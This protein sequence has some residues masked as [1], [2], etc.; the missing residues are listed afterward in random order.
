MNIYHSTNKKVLQYITDKYKD[1]KVLDIGPGVYPLPIATHFI[2]YISHQQNTI[3]IDMEQGNIPFDDK[4]FDFVY[5]R[6][7]LED[8]N[9]PFN[10]FNEICRVGKA[11][12]IETPSPFAEI[13]INVDGKLD[14]QYRGY[15]HHNY[16][17]WVHDNTLFF[18][19]KY[20]IVE[21]IN[22]KYYDELYDHWYWNTYL[23]Y[24]GVGPV[25]TYKFLRHDI[26]YNLTQNYDQMIQN[27]LY[28]SYQNITNF[29]KL[30]N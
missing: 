19:K 10:L 6:H 23:Y 30:Y 29:K 8:M 16:I 25:P 21:Y 3:C 11:F 7:V 14:T 12:Y 28:Q 1:K 24:D 17:V 4:Y 13:S 22:K 27:A 18:I 26:D 9:Y 5:C 15:V 20:P 2:D